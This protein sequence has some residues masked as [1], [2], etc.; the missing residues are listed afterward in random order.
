MTA[1]LALTLSPP[2]RAPARHAPAVVRPALD[3]TVVCVRAWRIRRR[4]AVHLG[5]PDGRWLYVDRVRR[6]T[7]SHTR[8]RYHPTR[9][10]VEWHTDDDTSMMVLDVLGVW[11]TD[12]RHSDDGWVFPPGRTLEQAL[13]Q[14]P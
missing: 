6:V 12:L 13:G 14:R 10:W 1:Q 9:K 8:P 2:Q 3:I 5:D 7:L 11:T 4:T